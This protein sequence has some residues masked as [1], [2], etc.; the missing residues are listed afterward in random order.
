M[1]TWGEG[2]LYLAANVATLMRYRTVLAGQA[3]E[4]SKAN[5]S[6]STVFE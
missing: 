3:W 4:A 1:R 2:S 6:S 5:F